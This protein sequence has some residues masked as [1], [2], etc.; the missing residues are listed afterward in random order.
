MIPEVSLPC[1]KFALYHKMGLCVTGVD[2][3][4]V[5]IS[6][7]LKPLGHN[8][9]GAKRPIDRLKLAAL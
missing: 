9:Y 4:M 5:E 2:W 6:P 3:A 1:S 7:S 8:S